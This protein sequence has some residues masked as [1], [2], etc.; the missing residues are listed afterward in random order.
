MGRIQGEEAESRTCE[1]APC[2]CRGRDHEDL[3]DR[4]DLS[5]FLPE[6]LV[7]LIFVTLS[8]SVHLFHLSL[9]F[10]PAT[11]P[12]ICLPRGACGHSDLCTFGELL[13]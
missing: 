11:F 10:L 7:T 8:L 6:V 3:R 12:P 5:L 1:R 4:E 2:G 13:V 9:L